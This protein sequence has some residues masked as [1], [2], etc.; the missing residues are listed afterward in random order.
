[1][2]TLVELAERLARED[3]VSLLEILDIRSDELVNR[4]LDRIEDRLAELREE[5][6]DDEDED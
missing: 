5:Y 1:M 3:E 2:L 6:D 4:F